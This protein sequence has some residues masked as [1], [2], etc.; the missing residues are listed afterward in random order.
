MCVCVCM[1]ACVRVRV[2]AC[3]CMRACGRVFVCACESLCGSSVRD[4]ECVSVR[5]WECE[6]VGVCV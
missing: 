6:S 2:C 3:A 1:F 4:C 5:L